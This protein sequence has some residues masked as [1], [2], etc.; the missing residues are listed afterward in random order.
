[1]WSRMARTDKYLNHLLQRVGV[2]PACSEE[3]RA[4]AELLADIYR[5]HGFEPELQEFDART[6]TRLPML[7]SGVL[8]FVGSIVAFLGGALGVV[9]FLLVAAACALVVLDKLDKLPDF[10]KGSLAPSQN[11]VAYHPAEGPLASPRN[12]PVVV[13]AHMDS[14]RADILFHPAFARIRPILLPALPFAALLCAVALL[15]ALFPFPATVGT[16]LRVVALL[17]SLVPLFYAVTVALNRFVLPYTTGSVCNKS[18]LAAL[19]GVMDAVSPFQ[20][21]DEFPDD[22]PFEEFLA[23]RMSHQE[24]VDDELLEEDAMLPEEADLEGEEAFEAPDAESSAGMTSSI[25]VDGFEET[26][27]MRLETALQGT[28]VIEPEPELE[29]EPSAAE[30]EEPSLYNEAGN[31][32]HGADVIRTL[33][34]VADHCELVYEGSDASEGPV[35]APTPRFEIVEGEGIAAE[36]RGDLSLASSSRPDDGR[37]AVPAEEPSDLPDEFLEPHGDLDASEHL[38]DWATDDGDLPAEDA[39]GTAHGDAVEEGSHEDGP[40]EE[41]VS[42]SDERHIRS[43]RELASFDPAE[44]DVP[45][46]FDAGFAVAPEGA[47]DEDAIE[48]PEVDSVPVPSAGD[49]TVSFPSPLP[50]SAAVQSASES[51]QF[52]TSE[53]V[54]DARDAAVDALMREI[55][56][57]PAPVPERPAQPS[58]APANPLGRRS[59]LFDLPDPTAAPSDP[60]AAPSAPSTAAV[61][62]VPQPAPSSPASAAGAFEVLE[63]P[64]APVQA[65]APAGEASSTFDVISAPAP[66]QDKPK[67]GIGRLFGRKK[68]QEESMGDWL[69]VGDDFDAKRSGRDIGSWDNFDDDDW[70]GGAAG[71]EGVSDQDM[72]EAIA[73]MGDDELLGHD[74]WFV[75]TGASGCGNIGARRFLE[76]HR[77][78]LRGVFVINLESIGAGELSI[79]TK[80]G[81][82]RVYRSDRRIQGL[83]DRVSTSFHRPFASVDMPYLDT[84]ALAAMSMS[85]RSATVAGAEEGH[86]ACAHCELDLPENVSPENVRTVAEVVT[87]V[88]RRS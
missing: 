74:I 68:N 41:E 6:F 8:M 72:V 70:K 61:P 65:S 51:T 49:A 43:A 31:I 32:R 52:F 45:V 76:E 48:E 47:E 12:R 40:A 88:I 25:P 58:P 63:S 14:P 87:E 28:A 85:L 36:E 56:P 18:S 77:D 34:M 15:L 39:A 33:G 55:S 4:A 84:D 29:P 71:A 86:L 26:S 27:E 30:P 1:M 37:A 82:R 21:D 78:K 50:Q 20:G 5:R 23:A 10:L 13:F 53:Q 54:R 17:A 83:L 60:F 16:V 69:G 64:S 66:K 44:L 24:Q 57:A 9:G 22:T 2:T 7:L 59:S 46:S 81:T 19:L 38:D 3:E 35:S 79:V 11:V 73:S 42:A 75:A 80:E 67:R 62:T